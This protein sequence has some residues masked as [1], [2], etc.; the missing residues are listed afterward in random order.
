MANWDAAREFLRRQHESFA[1][2]T[3]EE[4]ALVAEFS[5][6]STPEELRPFQFTLY[7]KVMP[8]GSLMILISAWLSH[9]FGMWANKATDGFVISPT[10][11]RKGF[12][13]LDQESGVFLVSQ[14]GVLTLA[15]ICR[16]SIVT[17]AKQRLDAAAKVAAASGN[18]QRRT[19]GVWP[20]IVCR[21]C[22]SPPHPIYFRPFPWDTIPHKHS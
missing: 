9:F 10:G 14:A 19:L 6:L 12:S 3:F 18:Y 17:M 1:L 11:T 4:L 7:R 22:A 16:E 5:E 2:K 15:R 20:Q 21:A 13:G 8:D